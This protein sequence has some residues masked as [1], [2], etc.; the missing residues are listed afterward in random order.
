M[1]LVGLSVFL[2]GFVALAAVT[3]RVLCE[4]IPLRG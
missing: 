2:F 3:T 1:K 4:A